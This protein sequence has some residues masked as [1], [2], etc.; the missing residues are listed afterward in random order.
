MHERGLDVDPNGGVLSGLR[1]VLEKCRVSLLRS[2]DS[3]ELSPQ[4]FF[5]YFTN[6]LS[7]RLSVVMVVLRSQDEEQCGLAVGC[8]EV[9]PKLLVQVTVYW[10]QQMKEGLR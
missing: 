6:I 5:Q 1:N 4:L 8:H 3:H 7:H 10:R 9:L 2:R